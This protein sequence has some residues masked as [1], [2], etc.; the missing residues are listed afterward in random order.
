MSNLKGGILKKKKRSIISKK[1]RINK[2]VT[3]RNTFGDSII[4]LNCDNEG[5]R[6]RDIR[7]IDPL[8]MV[9]EEEIHLS[10]VEKSDDS[11]MEISEEE[12]ID[13]LFGDKS[14]DWSSSDLFHCLY[15][16]NFSSEN[17]SPLPDP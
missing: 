6:L 13:L 5:E 16:S 4:S 12:N 17:R 3:F 10:K 1:V 14:Q 8:L 7:E 15:L 9:V 11:K 2:Y